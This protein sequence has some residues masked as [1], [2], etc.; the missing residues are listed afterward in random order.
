[1]GQGALADSRWQISVVYIGPISHMYLSNSI[2]TSEAISNLNISTLF[3]LPFFLL[4]LQ[5]AF[6]EG[7]HS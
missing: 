5:R 4:L 6:P 1:M 3:I 2:K 7:L